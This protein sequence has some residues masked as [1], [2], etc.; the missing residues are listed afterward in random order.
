MKRAKGDDPSTYHITTKLKGV[1][2]T[3]HLPRGWSRTLKNA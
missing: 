3:D 2:M 1:I